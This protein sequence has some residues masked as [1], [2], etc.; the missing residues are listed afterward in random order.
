[1]KLLIIAAYI[2]NP[3]WI[4]PISFILILHW[5]LKK[6]QIK[7]SIIYPLLTISPLSQTYRIPKYYILYSVLWVSLNLCKIMSRQKLPIVC[8]PEKAHCLFHKCT[9]QLQS[10][11]VEQL[12]WFAKSVWITNVQGLTLPSWELCTLCTHTH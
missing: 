3:L 8:A 9:K 7:E 12:Q 4:T 10:W 1:M 11:N 6:K 5:N 2:D